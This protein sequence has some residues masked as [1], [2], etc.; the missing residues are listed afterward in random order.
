MIRRQADTIPT[1]Y[2]HSDIVLQCKHVI[3]NET[4]EGG[5]DS[6]C[7]LDAAHI[8]GCATAEK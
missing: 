1:L 5:E 6:G 3:L 4:Y 8:V 2:T 7:L